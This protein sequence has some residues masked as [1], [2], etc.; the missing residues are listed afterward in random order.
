MS[1]YRARFHDPEGKRHH[2]FPTFGW[3]CAPDHLLTR[4]QLSNRG[5]RPAGQEP[6]GQMLWYSGRGRKP[7]HA[8]LYD[9]ALA[10]PKKA[11][12]EGMWRTHEAMMRVRRT[13]RRCTAV[14]PYDLSRK[15]QRVCLDCL[16]LEGAFA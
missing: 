8:Y 12:T 1:R 7:G 15:F 11:M 4:R 9:V 3:R 16:E 10:A 2:G 14:F 13:C 5:L 6:A